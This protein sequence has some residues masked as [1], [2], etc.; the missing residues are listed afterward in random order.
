MKESQYKIKNSDFS[1]TDR[2]AELFQKELDA[3]SSYDQITILE[4]MESLGSS[5]SKWL[6]RRYD[7]KKR[8]LILTEE[9]YEL[10]EEDD[11]KLKK[12]DDYYKSM[13]GSNS[14]R[15][16]DPVNYSQARV[17]F[18]EREN[19]KIRD[20]RIE[21]ELFKDLAEFCE[22]AANTLN[23]TTSKQLTNSVNLKQIESIV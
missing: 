1:K 3:D 23:Y 16:K 9:R 8:V 12:F 22:Y 21:I 11:E 6:K 13:S 17:K 2:L 4:R 15:D 10:M 7:L 5:I 19:S 20:M 18:L 14:Q